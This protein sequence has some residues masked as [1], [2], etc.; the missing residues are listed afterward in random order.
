M[1]QLM[2]PLRRQY[3]Y[4]ANAIWMDQIGVTVLKLQLSEVIKCLV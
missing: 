3:F 1:V 2:L 4:E